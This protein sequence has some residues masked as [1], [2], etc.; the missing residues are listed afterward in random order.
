MLVGNIL[1]ASLSNYKE[2]T[3][4]NLCDNSLTDACLPALFQAI[5][6]MENLKELNLSKNKIDKI[7][8]QALAEYVKNPNCKLETLILEKS[9]IDDFECNRIIRYLQYNSTLLN[10]DMSHVSYFYAILTLN[11]MDSTH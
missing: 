1:A 7:S 11:N 2:L 9:D 6:R 3:S 5:A 8:S 4:L 10:L